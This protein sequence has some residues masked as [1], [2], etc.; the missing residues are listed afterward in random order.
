MRIHPK[1]VLLVSTQ[2]LLFILYT[3]DLDWSLGVSHILKMVS[4]MI[5]TIGLLIVIIAILQL[6]KNLSPFPTPKTHSVLLQNG[7]YKVIRHPIYSGLILIFFGYGVSKDS[8][9]KIIIATLLFILFHFKTQYEEKQLQNK[10]PE[11]QSYK[12]KTNKFFP[13]LL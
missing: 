6:N 12:S 3:I 1:D 11:Y 8:G 10:F 4:L 5:A 7:L 9:Y 13:Y 2:F